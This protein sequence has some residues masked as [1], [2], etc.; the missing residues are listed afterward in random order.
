[1]ICRQEA[2]DTALKNQWAIKDG[3]I[4]KWQFQSWDPASVKVILH[5]KKQFLTAQEIQTKLEDARQICQREGILH[6]FHATRPLS[7]EPK[8]LRT[9]FLLQVSLRS[10]A[11]NNLHSILIELSECAVWRVLNIRLRPE[12]LQISQLAKQIE[13]CLRNLC[14]AYNCITLAIAVT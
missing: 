4:L 10:E 9:G 5:P 12:R 7:E 13:A 6:R 3:E 14:S 1:M 11:A 8:S 2:L